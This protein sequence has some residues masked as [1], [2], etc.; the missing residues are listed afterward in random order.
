MDVAASTAAPV[1]LAA[2]TS[3]PTELIAK[4]EQPV[5]V[6]AK[7]LA[8]ALAE[9][10]ATFNSAKADIA[11]QGAQRTAQASPPETSQAISA[12]TLS[13]SDLATFAAVRE[14]IR[15]QQPTSDKAIKS[16]VL[17]AA[18]AAVAA[19]RNVQERHAPDAVANAAPQSVSASGNGEYFAQLAGK[20]VP[21]EA[22]Y[23]MEPDARIAGAWR[24]AMPST[25]FQTLYQ[26]DISAPREPINTDFVS[27]F[28]SQ[29]DHGMPQAFEVASVPGL[30]VASSAT[31]GATQNAPVTTA[32]AGDDVTGSD[33]QGPLNLLG[34]LRYQ[35][36]KE[37]KDLMPPV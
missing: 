2:L 15:D 8:E 18:E 37:P 6:P 35:I 29:T 14:A 25:P 21:A 7:T 31:D 5:E 19:R 3:V 22:D 28:A 24:A 12:G 10:A 16:R 36:F 30:E 1:D 23:R 32:A 33:S 13:T 27:S 20:P 34:A 4:I 9:K 17:A 26:T 11:Q